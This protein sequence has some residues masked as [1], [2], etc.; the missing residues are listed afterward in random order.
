MNENRAQSDIDTTGVGNT[1]CH[2]QRQYVPH[3]SPCQT[4]FNVIRSPLLGTSARLN[5]SRIDSDG[6]IKPREHVKQSMRQFHQQQK[7]Q[8]I[9]HS[10]VDPK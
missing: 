1:D 8:M 2:V 7:T 5:V 9:S 10:K 3:T 6:F 4:P